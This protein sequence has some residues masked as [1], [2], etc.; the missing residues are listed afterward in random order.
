[1]SLLI[2]EGLSLGLDFDDGLALVRPAARANPMCN[3]V[4]AAVFAANKV[5]QRQRVMGAPPVT[6]AA[7]LPSFRQ[8]THERTPLTRNAGHTGETAVNGAIIKVAQEACQGSVGSISGAFGSKPASD[9]ST[10]SSKALASS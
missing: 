10:R 6:T 8:W 3:V 9:G 4:F 2:V 7:G 1:M 5:I